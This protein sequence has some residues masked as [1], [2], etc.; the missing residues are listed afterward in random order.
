[1][2]DVSFPL[3][4]KPVQPDCQTGS[5]GIRFCDHSTP[6]SIS[7]SQV[8]HAFLSTVLLLATTTASMAADALSPTKMWF[9]PDQPITINARPGGEAQLVLTD[10]KGKVLDPKTPAEL[11]A[12]KTVDLRESYR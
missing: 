9:A 7:R 2:P 3:H 4:L 10:F 5:A 1:M 12:D 11:A 6:E 8:M